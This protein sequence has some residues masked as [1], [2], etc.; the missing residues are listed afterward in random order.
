MRSSQSKMVYSF[1][2][3][4]SFDLVRSVGKLFCPES[5]TFTQPKTRFW[6]CEEYQAPTVDW[7]PPLC[8][9][10]TLKCFHFIHWQKVRK[11]IGN[12]D[13]KQSKSPFMQYNEIKSTCNKSDTCHFV[14]LLNII[15][16]KRKIW[17]MVFSSCLEHK[18]NFKF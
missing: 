8:R 16:R 6:D 15:S 4:S 1:F 18:Y 11:V 14:C 10:S 5:E 17:H 13:N 2:R 12:A 3:G 7:S 9:L